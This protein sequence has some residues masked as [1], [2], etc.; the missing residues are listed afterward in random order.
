V[1]VPLDFAAVQQAD[2]AL[3]ERWRYAVRATIVPLMASG[4]CV[5]RFVR[6][7]PQ[8]LPYYVFSRMRTHSLSDHD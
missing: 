8:H 6:G 7:G 2:A 5:M 3:A 1:Q 4:Y